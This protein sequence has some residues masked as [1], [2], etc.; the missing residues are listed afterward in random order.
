MGKQ[1]PFIRFIYDGKTMETD[2]KDNAGKSAKWDETFQFPNVL[3]RLKGQDSLVFQAYDKD[4]TSSDLLCKTEP[5]DYVDLLGT[6][7]AVKM[8]LDMF[9]EKG[10][11]CGKVVVTTQLIV[12]EKDPESYIQMNGNCCL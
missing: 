4:L 11:K 10:V 2:V 9:D 1:D 6:T 8:N 3:Q 12:I 5:I 7:D